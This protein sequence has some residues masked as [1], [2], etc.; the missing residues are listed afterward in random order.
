MLFLC[1]FSI[2]NTIYGAGNKMC[3]HHIN[4]ELSYLKIDKIRI[5]FII[6]ETTL[7]KTKRSSKLLY[8]RN[9]SI[10]YIIK[11]PSP[12]FSLYLNSFSSNI[13]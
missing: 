2:C 12:I 5:H 7:Y 13:L 3:I 4:L 6:Y 8:L 10:K 9:D 11:Y 1:V